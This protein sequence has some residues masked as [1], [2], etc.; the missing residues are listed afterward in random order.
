MDSGT[1]LDANGQFTFDWSRVDECVRFFMGRDGVKRLEG[2]HIA[3]M[4]HGIMFFTTYLLRRN[5]QGEMGVGMA[6]YN[7]DESE[8]LLRQYLPAL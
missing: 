8:N 2:T 3:S 7:R 1:Q 5:A 4:S 6:A